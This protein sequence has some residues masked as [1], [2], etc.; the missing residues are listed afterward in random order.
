MTVQFLH[1]SSRGDP[2]VTPLSVLDAL[3]ISTQ[4]RGAWFYENVKI[5]RLLESL[6]LV[7]N[8]AP[9]VCGSTRFVKYNPDGTVYER[10]WH[11]ELAYNF[12][13]DPGV[14]V[15]VNA[16]YSKSLQ[17]ILKKTE[18][19]GLDGVTCPIDI[20]PFLCADT[21]PHA[22][23]SD[24]PTL[25]IKITRLKCGT[26]VIGMGMPHIVADV[27]ALQLTLK[28][29]SDAYVG[30]DFQ[31]PIFAPRDVDALAYG[32]FDKRDPVALAK[33]QHLPRVGYDAWN[34]RQFVPDQYAP[35]SYGPEE[36]IARE[37]LGTP[38]KMDEFMATTLKYHFT[39]Q[40]I[41]NIYKHVTESGA[42]VSHM[43]VLIAHMWDCIAR[44]RKNAENRLS[45]F[46]GLRSR[47]Q[48]DK[49][50]TK[51]LG[52]FV[53][54][55]EI[56]SNGK[57]SITSKALSIRETISKYTK[58]LSPYILHELGTRVSPTRYIM[59]SSENNYV[60]M[61]TW[62]NRDIKNSDINFGTKLVYFERASIPAINSYCI[63]LP[64]IGDKD[65]WYENGASIHFAAK[66]EVLLELAQDPEL[67][68]WR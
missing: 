23:F 12:E 59:G 11:T 3:V 55:A 67:R 45:L 39:S 48:S 64:A 61:T 19:K 9:Y 38:F 66:K 21:K 35:L 47:L 43:N 10:Y 68:K 63:L 49:D 7:I 56:S 1:P 62:I 6:Q 51:Y 40:E 53:N 34:S 54:N 28:S 8:R 50:F 25:R 27:Q 60:M 26:V 52:S 30:N 57:E 16:E 18:I 65:A 36:L 14:E 4:S 29:W 17:E 33:I 20:S 46:I 32:F 42:Q 2:T 22:P 13:T 58:D 31:V 41:E 5:D 37:P 44:A 15:E 24:L